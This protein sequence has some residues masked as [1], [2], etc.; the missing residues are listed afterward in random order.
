MSYHHGEEFTAADAADGPLYV[1]VPRGEE[2]TLAEALAL[3]RDR[4]I[5]I[6][7]EGEH[8]GIPPTEALREVGWEVEP[9]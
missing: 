1:F 2:M 8:P 3:S 7:V 5:Y 9:E 6:A 4:R